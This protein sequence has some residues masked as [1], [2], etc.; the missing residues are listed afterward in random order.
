MA[1]RLN[2]FDAL[3][4]VQ[5]S[6]RNYVETFQNVDDD[7]I[8][9]WIDDRIDTGK[10][11]WKKPFVELNQRFKYGT[12]LGQFVEDN[13][14][15]SSVLDVFD[16]ED[17]NPIKPYKHQAEAIQSIDHGNTIVSTGTGSGKS[18][19]FGIPLVSHCLDGRDRG[20]D[21]VK[22]VIV[23]PM[24]AL[25]NSQYEEFAKRLD[26][27]G[28]RLGLYTGDTPPNPDS[29]AEFLQ[30]FGRKEAYDCEVISREEMQEDPPDILMTNYV[31]LDYILTR[32]EDKDLF[33]AAH[34]GALQYL[35]L[36]EI[37]T[38]TG[39]QGADV[40]ALIRRL[41][42]H[43]NTGED[44]TCIGTSATVQNEAGLEAEE[45]IAE[46]S[47]RIFGSPVDSERVIEETYYP[48]HFTGGE[49]LPDS[50]KVTEADI[51][52]F[53]GTPDEA[54]KLAERL[55]DRSL[56]K[57]ETRSPETLGEVL[58]DHP[59]IAFLD[60]Q[61]SEQSRQIQPSGELTDK[62][63]E[64]LVEQYQAE[65]RP[66]ISSQAAR[67]ELQAALLV[68]T[69][70]TT[71]VQGDQ[72]PIFIPKLHSFFSQGSGLVACLTPE[73]L[74]DDDPHL[75]DAGDI[76]CRHCA[77]KHDRSRQAFPLS[78]CRACGQEYYTLVRRDDGRLTSREVSDLNVEEN[79]TAGYAMRG[80]W[81]R[82]EV[83]LPANW[84]DD[85]GRLRDTW[86]EAVPQPATYCPEHNRLT[87]GHH[88]SG[89]LACG[90]F[91]SQGIEVMWSKAEFL[92]CANCGV[93]HTRMGR[94]MEL[95]KMFKFGT[96]GRSTA[97]DVLIGS[98]MQELPN[99]RQKTIAFSDNR[100]DTA[101]QAAHINN[102]YQRVK[103][104]RALYE[105]LRTNGEVSLAN[106]GN[107]TFDALNDNDALPDALQTTMFGVPD[108]EEARYSDYL[109]FHMLLELRKSQ[110]RGQQ[111][112]IDVGLLDVEYENLDKLAELDEE[113]EDVPELADED[114]E[115]RYEY[116]K[117]F[118]DLFRRTA[119]VDHNIFTN[120]G[121]F[122]RNTLNNLDDEAMFHKQQFFR[123]PEGFSDT[124][125]TSG[126][127]QIHR[128]TDWRSRHVKWTT[129][130]LD[131]GS[132]RAAE[133]IE[134][135]RDLL[136]D[137]DKLPLLTEDSVY[138]GR[139]AY[140]LNPSFV[141]LVPHDPSDVLVCPK[142]KTVMTRSHIQKC[143]N[144]SC[145][146]V[147]P[148]ETDLRDSYFHDLY[149]EPFGE[150]VDIF[151][152]EH[153][154]QIEGDL[155]K[156]LE[157]RF[158]EGDDLNTIVCTPTME[159]G[160]DI[161]DL[162][163]VFMRNVPP[164]PS[165]YAQRSGRAG[166]QDQPSLVTTFCGSGFG[167]ASHDQYFYQRPQRII[168][169][170]ISPPTFLLNN[171]DL[172]ESHINALVLEVID[173]KLYGKIRQILDIEAGGSDYEIIESYRTDLETAIDRHRNQIIEAV[174][175]AFARERNREAYQEWFTDEFIE[176][177]VDGFV[178]AFDD[179]FEPWRVE[180]TRLTREL[181][182]LNKKLE[183]ER[184]EY[185]ERR[186]RDA[187]E[188]RLE[189]MRDGGKRFYTYQY[190][191]SQGFLPNYGFPR[192]NCTLGFT[193]KE[194]DIQRDE[195]QAIREF[196]PGNNVYYR[197][198]R[199][200]VQ[201]ARPKTRDAEPITRHKIVCPECETILMGDE[202]QEAAGC[203][204]CGA[205][206]GGVHTNPNTMELPDMR[207]LP[208][209]NI[210]SDDEERRRE[211]Y[212][213]N[214]YY[215]RRQ[216]QE[217]ELASDAVSASVTYEPNA[218][219]VTVNSGIRGR[220]E[221]ELQGFALC[222]ECNR[223]LTSYGQI[224]NHIDDQCYANADAEAIRE[225]IELYTEGNYDTVTVTTPLPGDVEQ[226]EH[227][228][229]YHTL[230]EA[231][232]QGVLVE[233]DLDE[234]ELSTFVKPAPGNAGT[235]TIVLH[236]TSEGGV[237]ALHDLTNPTKER[238]ARVI[239]ESLDVLHANDPDGCERAC[240]ECLMSYFNQR[241]HPLFDRELVMPWLYGTTAMTL[242]PIEAATDDEH[243]ERLWEACES[244][245]ER[246]VLEAVREEGYPYPDE[247][248]KTIYNGDEPVVQ[249]DFYYS[250]G[251]QPQ[252][253]VV[254]VD[255]PDHEKEHVQR[256]DA[257]KRERLL[258]MNYRYVSISNP[259]NVP[260]VWSQI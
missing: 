244:S 142:C 222:T 121:D 43:T 86:E 259:G 53:D 179:A 206:F 36:D 18:F 177:Q 68:G 81:D 62:E 95:S 11:L 223:W 103:F 96:V 125:D 146:N 246:K 71:E 88:D 21:G 91:A 28:L 131:I 176:E 145:A 30:Q 170:E 13:I 175:G 1:S 123:F 34:K 243:F 12:A 29:K 160:I 69:V 93:S 113:W 251:A 229:F 234:A 80:E 213:I 3:G 238:F 49:Q 6:Y 149:T 184:G 124:A 207:A 242:D 210:T 63:E 24:N 221:D 111:S 253:I 227:E 37:H 236:E 117:A 107:R 157:T 172:I 60:E 218:Q 54:T 67:R 89:Q 59:T 201:Y 209:E 4:D 165:N 106:I 194:D 122:R 79:E 35:V 168:A 48:I 187:I 61:L 22:A 228:S 148:E 130:A 23:Y 181:R 105:A 182:R 189:D 191:R 90:C 94:A 100:Q 74:E 119:A 83:T 204:V 132:D 19:A 7:T 134:G 188:R 73:T 137:P 115:F 240:Y 47:A 15:H 44:L 82:Y 135:V 32:H 196:A 255:G 5:T 20:E 144:S 70:A 31:M 40:A 171:R 27:S 190:L 239:K 140:M 41:R 99:P 248:Q 166:R 199:H 258:R 136:S 102:L 139:R 152:A 38:Y 180:Y 232:Y 154:G 147:T 186:E 127:E 75:S 247:A 173:F 230:K 50:V 45:E 114:P 85:E 203:P 219:I 98:T 8:A 252:P 151:A 26:G 195:A 200:G 161:G 235:L 25:A 215:E 163:N 9:T 133:V 198:E 143:L 202:A 138:R 92:F 208:E 231:L 120:F 183:A 260:E 97:T 205:S 155:R 169:G 254:F 211:G 197:G 192:S 162:S 226:D 87:D 129:R 216:V 156:Q 249:A 220:D 164:N 65:Y 56:S 212:D 46:F 16:D 78:F 17:G 33:P 42:E 250:D 77:R 110:Q 39:H 72:Q 225:G 241:E 237:G 76:E 128:F 256:D 178:E 126:T 224:E 14:L 108:D 112:L 52:R 245:L 55:T 214:H 10:I 174:N 109:L 57:E 167:R 118:L 159:L 185:L 58:I 2:P 66:D 217:Y 104:R 84:F 158:R 141:R 257:A 193:T 153:S 51:Q 101:L 233:F 150:A 116:C 64:T